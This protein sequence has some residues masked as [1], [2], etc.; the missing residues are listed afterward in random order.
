MTTELVIDPVIDPL[1]DAVTVVI[2]IVRGLYDPNSTYPPVGGGTATVHFVSGEGPSWDPLASR[3]G[4]DADGEA[5]DPFIWVRLV[6]RYMS[7]TFPEPDAVSGCQGV[8]TIAL[9]VGVGR[10]VNI[11]PVADYTVIAREAEWGF[12]DAFRLGKVACL[13]AGQF[14]DDYQVAYEPALPEGP[15]GGGIVWSTTVYIGSIA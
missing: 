15:E 9:E 12:D 7:R 5:C 3:I 8:D 4:E 1:F 11:D 13:V 2:N 6:S 10:C 14:G